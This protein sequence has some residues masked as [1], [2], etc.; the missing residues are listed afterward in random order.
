MKW[1]GPE[2][3]VAGKYIEKEGKDRDND[4]FYDVE[5][6]YNIT[7][8]Q[9]QNTVIGKSKRNAQKQEKVPGPGY[10]SNKKLGKGLLQTIGKSQRAEISKKGGNDKFY[11]VGKSKDAISKHQ[12]VAT[13]GKG[14]KNKTLKDDQLGP[15]YYK[16]QELSKGP[17][18][19]IGIKYE[20]KQ[21]SENENYKYYDV[22][23]GFDYTTH[24]IQKPFIE[25]SIRKAEIDN[26]T[27]GVG[28]YSIKPKDNLGGVT[29]GKKLKSSLENE[30]AP[31]PGAY[32]PSWDEAG[33]NYSN[34]IKFGKADRIPE[35]KHNEYPGPGFYKPV[36]PWDKGPAIGTG[37]RMHL[38]SDE[39]PGPSDYN[40]PTMVPVIY[41]VNKPN[42]AN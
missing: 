40:L 22:Q 5:K 9:T 26:N 29:M 4:R 20:L 18:C 6:S 42:A 15:G 19:P 39:T 23:K 8:G 14:N 3:T 16:I 37:E 28:S 21:D 13:M 2:Y 11:D 1:G 7:Q 36:L 12:P 24:N 30:R 32:K 10:Y 41:S 34:D 17:S 33:I 31:G 27:P 38:N 25:T 35:E